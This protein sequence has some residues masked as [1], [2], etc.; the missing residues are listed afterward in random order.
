[1]GTPYPQKS[2]VQSSRKFVWRLAR[3][4]R[5]CG[6]LPCSRH[7]LLAFIPATL[8]TREIGCQIGDLVV[9]RALSP[10]DLSLRYAHHGV[11][12]SS[13]GNMQKTDLPQAVGLTKQDELTKQCC[14]AKQSDMQGSVKT[15]YPSRNWW[16]TLRPKTSQRLTHAAEDTA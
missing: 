1:M 14:P 16:P 7:R 2:V 4:Q 11:M 3:L 6:F 8:N 9:T 15:L 10:A 13:A 5:R 12:R